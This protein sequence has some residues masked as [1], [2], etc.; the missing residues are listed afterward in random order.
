MDEREAYIALNMMGKVGPVG[1]RSLVSALG[2]ARAVF[3]SDQK[4]L[5]NAKGIGVG[6]SEAIMRQRDV[7]DWCGEIERADSA[8]VRIITQIDEEY[9]KQLLEIHDPPLALYLRGNLESRDKH[10]IAIVGTRRATHYGMETAE[11]MAFQLAKTGFVI[12]SGLAR[13]IDTAAHR[14]AL[15]AKGRTLAVIGSA[16]DCI[17]PP[18]NTEL[19]Q[20]ISQ[21]GAVISEFPF[22]KQPDK[23]TFPMRNRIVSGLSMGV[24]VVEAGFKSGALIT[25]GQALEQGRSVFA[26]PG[27]IDSPASRGTL[28]LIKHG[29]VS[30]TGVDDIINE[31]EFLLPNAGCMSSQEQ[32]SGPQ[33]SEKET[34][35]LGFLGKGERDIDSLIRISGMK[36]SEVNAVLIGL[37]M[38]KMICMLPGRIVEAKR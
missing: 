21:H 6:L 26:I 12:V 22:G 1:V 13:G 17:Y 9:P 4:A 32:V 7:V 23:T 5:L 19:A 11:K 34:C 15:K 14:G 10:A 24:L 31:Y 3:E 38:K 18:S 33:L 30:V 35:L 27:R 25:A 37:E 36:S 16:L 29:A 28:G 2:S 8:G 20:D